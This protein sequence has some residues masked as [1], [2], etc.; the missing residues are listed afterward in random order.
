VLGLKA[1]ANTARP[2]SLLY[3]FGSPPFPDH[4]RL[5]SKFALTLGYFF[6]FNTRLNVMILILYA[7]VFC[8]CVCLA[9]YSVGARNKPGSL[10]EHP[11]LLTI[12]TSL[13]PLTNLYLQVVLN[14]VEVT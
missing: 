14:F 11:V 5:T 7:W 1:Y 10:G 2:Q 9:G 6:F 4:A 13:Q 8:L 12:E 3:S